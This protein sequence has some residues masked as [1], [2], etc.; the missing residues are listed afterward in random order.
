MA[1]PLIWLGVGVGS[2]LVGQHLRQQDMRAKG[3]VA[4]FPGE[5][6]IA[7]KAKGGAI[8]CCG[9][10][11]VFDHSGI[12]LDDGVA[13]L[14]GN[15]LIRAVSASRFMQNRSGDT[16]FIACDSS[17]KPLID[18]L[19]A[20]RASAQLFSYRDYHVLN[21]NCHRFS[22]QCISGENRRITQ[23]ATLNHLMAEHFQQTVY[24]HPLQYCS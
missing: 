11:G 20:Q 9:I 1:V 15:G 21:N 4:Q 7:V 16:I 22:W 2:W 3:V 24:W 14:K 6:A 10:Y 5:R 18:P 23:F 13:E 19:A 12:W 8:V 17:G